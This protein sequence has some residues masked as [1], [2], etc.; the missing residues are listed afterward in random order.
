LAAVPSP[1]HEWKLHLGNGG[2]ELQYT[3]DA[4]EE[5]T[6]IPALLRRLGELG[7]GFT[8]LQTRQSSLEDIFVDL[9]SERS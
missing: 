4:A 9:V 7:I 6:G 1:L 8:D 5:R 2:S 3:F